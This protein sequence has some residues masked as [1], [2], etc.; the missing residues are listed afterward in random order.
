MFD[1]H[2]G[3]GGQLQMEIAHSRSVLGFKKRYKNRKDGNAAQP[4]S[5]QGG[6]PQVLEN[7]FYLKRHVPPH[8]P[9]G[10]AKAPGAGEEGSKRRHF[11]GPKIPSRCRVGG[12]RHKQWQ[13]GPRWPTRRT[14]RIGQK[15]PCTRSML[16][17][18]PS[19]KLKHHEE[20]IHRHPGPQP[21][22]RITGKTKAARCRINSKTSCKDI[23]AAAYG[24][25][26][27]VIPHTN[28]ANICSSSLDFSGDPPNS[29]GI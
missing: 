19:P 2:P 13:V 4:P 22:R 23:R 8:T 26:P 1:G 17:R 21:R 9:P 16:H 15:P 24:S 12:R 6:Q 28:E 10:D 11:A 7:H 5:K 27:K 3:G 29:R 18:R 20:G 25:L 14:S